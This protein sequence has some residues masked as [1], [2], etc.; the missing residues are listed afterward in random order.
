MTQYIF[1]HYDTSPFSEKVRLAFG[2]KRLSWQS[3]IIPNMNPK[4]DLVPLT[5][6]Y[7]RTPVMQI[8]ADIY[9][10]TQI[11]LDEIERRDPTPSL[12]PN[13]EVSS[14]RAMA[15]YADRIWFQASVAVIFGELGDMVPE[16]FK[17][18]REQLSGRPFN[19]DAMKAAAPMMAEQFRA[20][21]MLVNDQLADGRDWLLGD[22]MS[23]SDIHAYM[24]Y[25]F[26]AGATPHKLSWLED[27]SPVAKWVERVKATGHGTR[28][29]LDSK[30]ALAIANGAV[31]E[32]EAGIVGE[33]ASGLAVGDKVTVMADDYGQDPIA[34]EV[35]R[36]E[37]HRIAIKRHDPAVGDVVVHFP[38]IGF[39][40]VRR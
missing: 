10:D 8:G 19:T 27:T 25:W 33:E 7:R 3:V 2:L 29:E 15:L 39:V 18:D 4:P 30:D 17:K 21:L 11:I 6:G 1:H 13:G 22:A 32:T 40:V 5:G 28:T 31:S 34:G 37:P 23:A 12:F 36:L 24:N 35:L 20:H 26:V 14:A 16:D 9:C 38:R